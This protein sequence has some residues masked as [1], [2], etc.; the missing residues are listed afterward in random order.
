MVLSAYTLLVV[1]ALIL[2]LVHA[3][4]SPPRVPLWIPVLLVCIALLITATIPIR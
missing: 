4:V 3:L 2:T 1:L